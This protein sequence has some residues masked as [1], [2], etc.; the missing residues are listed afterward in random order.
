[1]PNIQIPIIGPSYTVRSP[2]FDCARTVNLYPVMDETGEGK[3]VKALYGTPGLR[4]L[5]TLGG[6]GGI[7]ATYRPAKGDAIV[8]RGASV[9]RV[10]PS[11]FSTLIGKINTSLGVV[12]ISDNGTTAVL[13]DGENGYTL[14]LTTNKL[15]RI[16]DPAF[17]GADYVDFLDSYLIFSKPDSFTFYISGQYEVTFDP[18]DFASAEDTPQDIVRHFVDH[19]EVWFFKRTSASIFVDSGS[20]D[21]PFAR[22]QTAIEV[23]CAAA[24]SVCK[25]DNSIFWLGEEEGGTGSVWRAQGYT[26]V[27]ISTE[28]VEHAIQGYSRIDDAIAY[29]YQQEKHAFYVLTFPTANATWVY[30]AFTQQW[31]ERAWRKP[32][33]GSLN[34]HRSNCHMFFGGEH[35]VGDWE[36]GNIYALDLDYYS[37]NGDPMPAIRTTGHVSNPTYARM[38]FDLLQVDMETGVGLQSGQGSDPQA[39][40]EWSDDGGHVWSNKHSKSMGK[41]GQYRA[42]CRWLRMGASRDRV[43]RLTITDPVKRAIIGAS[44]NVR[45]GIS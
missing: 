32:A 34:R 25:L 6:T 3:A 43:Y 39:L 24:A 44:A 40:L 42:R 7:R 1:M 18:L 15:T 8:V 13:V 17:Y 29:A 37:D 21:F 23:G 27:R 19:R 26:P 16:T 5:A 36:S 12:S 30:D 14:N 33:D 35:V 28:A 2:N 4:L 11:W 31:H 41:V 9:Y 20:A 45:L 10:T 22:T 38:F